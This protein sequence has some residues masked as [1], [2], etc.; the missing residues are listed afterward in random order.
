MKR[1]SH[2]APHKRLSQNP[3][4]NL[5]VRRIRWGVSEKHLWRFSARWLIIVSAIV[6][7]LWLLSALPNPVRTGV[8]DFVL[9]LVIISFLA[10][11]ALD[12]TCM[13]AALGSI[14]GELSAGRWDLLRLTSLT[15]PQIIAAKHGAAQLRAWRMMILVMGLR[16]AIWLVL[17]IN[18]VLLLSQP[19]GLGMTTVEAFTTLVAALMLALLFLIFVIEP[20]WRM[21]AVTALGV[22][23]SAR[24]RHSTS[25]VLA[26]GG[27]VAAL[28][29]GQGFVVVAVM[30]AISMTLLPLGALET[31]AYQ[32]VF[33]APALLVVVILLTVYG[34]YSVIQTWGLRRAERWI[35]R[36]D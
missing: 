2:L 7:P 28:W 11:L 25:G 10:G 33:V 24:A 35:A 8:N 17:G 36:I 27:F 14:N 9:L 34:Y 6:L 22:A 23:I 31:A 1:L 18:F 19:W 16:L 13:A 4:F 29:L 21:R 5:E 20:F 26:A 12:Y 32:V 3:L 30:L 15:I